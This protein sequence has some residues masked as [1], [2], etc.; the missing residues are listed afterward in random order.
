MITGLEREAEQ[1]LKFARERFDVVNYILDNDEVLIPTSDRQD[2]IMRGIVNWYASEIEVIGLEN[3]EEAEDKADKLNT[4]LITTRNHQTY[5]DIACGRKALESVEKK[6]FADLQVHPGGLDIYKRYRGLYLPANEIAVVVVAPQDT[7][8]ITRGI[9][10]DLAGEFSEEQRKLLEACKSS[11]SMLTRRSIRTLAEQV[12]LTKRMTIF[13]ET[14]F[15]PHDGLTQ[16]P[17]P[18][19]SAFFKKPGQIV[20]PIRTDGPHLIF[21]PDS[22][23]DGGNRPINFTFEMV[24]GKPFT[25][26]QAHKAYEATEADIALADVVFKPVWDLRPNRGDPRYT[27]F[28]ADLPSVYDYPEAA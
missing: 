9:T 3:L 4:V 25:T 22:L 1:L 17:K 23:E 21:G 14:D 24:I 7:M 16:R 13:P 8:G 26:D 15:P 6:N 19:V 5:V 28:F 18:E 27:R 20:L 2:R 12:S 11:F 10:G